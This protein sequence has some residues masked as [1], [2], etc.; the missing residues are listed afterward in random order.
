MSR[1]FEH[2]NKNNTDSIPKLYKRCLNAKIS[3]NKI[4]LT[5]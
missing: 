1:I 5:D 2:I 4:K 3:K